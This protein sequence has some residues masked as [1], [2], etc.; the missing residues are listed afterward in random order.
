M[1]TE[2]G[3]EINIVKWREKEAGAR[4]TDEALRPK[5]ELG[6]SCIMG[7]SDSKGK[8][9]WTARNEI[10]KYGI[11]K[12]ECIAQDRKKGEWCDGLEII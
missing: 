8:Q 5:A 2:K 3:G 6:L 11:E 10:Y 7:W 9:C 12:E 4:E 1:V